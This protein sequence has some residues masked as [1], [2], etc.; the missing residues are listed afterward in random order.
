MERC[1]LPYQLSFS[2]AVTEILRLLI[3]LP[4]SSP[5][6][7]PGHLKYF[8]SNAAMLKLPPRREREYEGKIR[9]KKTKYPFKTMPDTLSDRH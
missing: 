1:Y 8:Y 5:G 3:G 9:Q 2:G 7:V 4:G 6:A